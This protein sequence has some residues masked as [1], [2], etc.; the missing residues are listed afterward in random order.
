MP[1]PSELEREDWPMLW[2]CGRERKPGEDC[3]PECGTVVV[4]SIGCRGEFRCPRKD[5]DFNLPCPD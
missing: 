5:Q 1:N 2:E 4:R 3:C